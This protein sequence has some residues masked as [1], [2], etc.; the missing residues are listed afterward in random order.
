[1]QTYP[2]IFGY[3]TFFNQ[4]PKPYFPQNGIKK[5]FY[6][7]KNGFGIFQTANSIDI[8][9][10]KTSNKITLVLGRIYHPFLLTPWSEDKEKILSSISI[11]N[12]K[13]LEG[14]FAIIECTISEKKGIMFSMATDKFASKMLLYI[15]KKDVFYFSTH[16]YGL[17]ALLNHQLPPISQTSLIHYYHFGQTA[18]DS[19]LFE[20]INK[21][22]PASILSIENQNVKQTKYFTLSDLYHPQAF[23]NLP[24]ENR[25]KY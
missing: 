13:K 5:L 8:H 16:F 4:S 17:K 25:Q 9:I 20:G 10:H 24:E 23:K 12:I 7:Q 1:M 11:Q 21:L 22:P 14:N 19:T 15:V 18:N 6:L 3:I 2:I